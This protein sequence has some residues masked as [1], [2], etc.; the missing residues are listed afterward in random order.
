EP[1][2]GRACVPVLKA[3]AQAWTGLPAGQ[4]SAWVGPGRAAGGCVTAPGPRGG[5]G[6]LQGPKLPRANHQGQGA[7]LGLASAN[8][9]GTT[10]ASSLL[11]QT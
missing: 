11:V 8:R 2:Q 10:R 9:R 1:L 5:L 6:K 7:G 4:G 3:V